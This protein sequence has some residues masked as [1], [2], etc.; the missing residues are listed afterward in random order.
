MYAL[1]LEGYRSPDDT[2]SGGR[3]TVRGLS[4]CSNFGDA[5]AKY[6]ITV[7]ELFPIIW[8]NRV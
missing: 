6:K 2:A 3:S 1:I 5:T 8:I 4:M 7:S